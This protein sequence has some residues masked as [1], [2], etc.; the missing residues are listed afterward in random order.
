MLVQYTPTIVMIKSFSIF[1]GQQRRPC[2]LAGLRRM[3]A[4]SSRVISQQKQGL[5]ELGLGGLA[6]EH[7]PNK[8]E[9]T[10]SIDATGSSEPAV[11]QYDHLPG[12]IVDMYHTGVPEAY[13]GK[14]VAKHLAKAALDYF[15]SQDLSIRLSCTYLQKYVRDNPLEK[16]TAKL[17]QN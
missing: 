6:V 7:N 15:S 5:A 2:F 1:L 17:E 8:C 14:G 9:F 16:Y 13:R 12:N 3:S 11:L 4:T 10:I